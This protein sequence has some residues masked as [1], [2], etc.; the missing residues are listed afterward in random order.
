MIIVSAA[1]AQIENDRLYNIIQITQKNQSADPRG[2][3][4]P[5]GGGVPSSADLPDCQRGLNG[6]SSEEL[7]R[8]LETSQSRLQEDMSKLSRDAANLQNLSGARSVP[9]IP[10]PPH[11]KSPLSRQLWLLSCSQSL[12]G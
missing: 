1:L 2:L 6:L 9:F 10:F 12:Q 3:E 5:G 8:K 7:M 4:A 11:K